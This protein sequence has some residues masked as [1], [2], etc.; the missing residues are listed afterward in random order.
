VAHYILVVDDDHALRES[1]CEALQLEGYDTVCV[2][3]GEAALRHLEKA[4]PPCLIL[5]DLMM[6]VMD[7]PT[8]RQRILS[9]PT[10]AGIPVVVLTAG[11]AQ[12]AAAVPATEVLLK[13]LRIGKVLDVVKEHCPEA[14]S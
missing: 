4:E 8:F 14:Q 1:I 13:P 10:L 9:R 3:H 12:M 11:G 6:P 5:L 2:E 7:G